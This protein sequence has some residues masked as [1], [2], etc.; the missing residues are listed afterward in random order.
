[1]CGITN[2][3]FKHAFSKQLREIVSDDFG[4]KIW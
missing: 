2:N 4:V 1:L 3:E